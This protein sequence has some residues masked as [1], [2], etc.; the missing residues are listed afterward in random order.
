MSGTVASRT[1]DVKRI[2]MDKSIKCRTQRF[3]DG[4]A[5]QVSPNRSRPA[6]PCRPLP[7]AVGDAR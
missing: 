5:D 7:P 4:V 1:I 2:S 6:W 3:I